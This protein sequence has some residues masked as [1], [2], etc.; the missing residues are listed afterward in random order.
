MIVTQR[1]QRDNL[2]FFFFFYFT[3]RFGNLKGKRK[4]KKPNFRPRKSNQGPFPF[5]KSKTVFPIFQSV[6]GGEGGGERG[7]AG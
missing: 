1:E 4:K 3:L 5:A 6:E 7:L 2:V